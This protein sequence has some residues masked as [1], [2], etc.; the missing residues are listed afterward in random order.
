[1]PVPTQTQ[2]LLR[3]E[4]IALD[5]RL[6]RTIDRTTSLREPARK[7]EQTS[8]TERIRKVDRVLIVTKRALDRLS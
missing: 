7:Y 8:E 3:R 2:C 6:C 4:L 1:M 5:E